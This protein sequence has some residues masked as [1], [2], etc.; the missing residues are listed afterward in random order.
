MSK[1]SLRVA[2]VGLGKMGL[3]HASLLNAMPGV[4][5]VALCDRNKMILGFF[6][7]VFTKPCIV[8]D[9]EKLS[10][11]NLDAVYITTPIPT[12]FPVTEI[13]YSKGIAHNLFVEKTRFRL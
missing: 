13:I 11:M 3:V 1:P 6:R 8:D 10:S 5:L 2:V 4:Q 7:K 9:V 12:H